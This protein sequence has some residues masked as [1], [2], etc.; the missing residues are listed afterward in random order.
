MVQL[1]SAGAGAR[2]RAL[3]LAAV[4]KAFR[5][6]PGEHLDVVASGGRRRTGK[7]RRGLRLP[8][9]SA[10]RAAVEPATG[11]VV[12]SRPELR[13]TVTERYRPDESRTVRQT[14]DS[15]SL[16]HGQSSA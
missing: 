3:D 14:A 12:R 9:R 8:R 7:A 2:Y 4:H 1:C 10:V 13:S 16:I 6:Q 11:G 5:V 15:H